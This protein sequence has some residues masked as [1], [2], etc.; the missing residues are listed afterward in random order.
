MT[1]AAL[2]NLLQRPTVIG[3]VLT[4]SHLDPD[5]IRR[6]YARVQALPD[7]PACGTVERD[8]SWSPCLIWR[9]A[10]NRDGYGLV[11]VAPKSWNS[12]Q[13]M[14]VHRLMYLLTNGA[15]PVDEEIHHRCHMRGCL[16]PAHLEAMT[17]PENMA[18]LRP[19]VSDE[20]RAR[21]IPF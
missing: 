3:H 8:G 20:E 12:V 17:G 4:V 1:L 5:A 2:A 18:D 7:D 16:R 6:F 15:L 13:V 21:E 9:G 14:T 11:R 19:V 10:R